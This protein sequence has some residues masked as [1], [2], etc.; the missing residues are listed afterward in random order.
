MNVV[1]GLIVDPVEAGLYR[2]LGQKA[3]LLGFPVISGYI[4]SPAFI[5]KRA[6]RVV[7]IFIPGLC[8]T[9]VNPRPLVHHCNGQ[10]VQAVLTSLEQREQQTAPVWY[11]KTQDET[12]QKHL[13]FTHLVSGRCTLPSQLILRGYSSKTSFKISKKWIYIIEKKTLILAFVCFCGYKIRIFRNWNNK[14]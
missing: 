4:H 7:T 14:H 3:V 10:P 9:Q 13:N 2:Q 11:I 1:L 5:V 12:V 6:L 8:H